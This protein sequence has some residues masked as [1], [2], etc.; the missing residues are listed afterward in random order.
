M[1][2]RTEFLTFDGKHEKCPECTNT[3]KELI[4]A[5]KQG[6]VMEMAMLSSKIPEESRW[7]ITGITSPAEPC[8]RLNEL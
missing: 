8:E 6:P 7:L 5:S 2:K 4:K 1:V 3:F